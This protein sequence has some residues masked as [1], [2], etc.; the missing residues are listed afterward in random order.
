MEH[1]HTLQQS[2]GEHMQDIEREAIE[3]EGRNHQSFLTACRVA[4]QACPPEACGIPM[5][6][7]QL[8]MGNMSLATLLAISPGHPPQWEKWPL[9]LPIQLHQW[10][11]HPNGDAVH[12]G[13][14]LLDQLLLP[15]NLLIRTEKRESPSQGSMKTAWRPFIRTPI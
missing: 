15:K 1:A 10:H 12:L 8:L 5:Y 3:E 9:Q 11:P 6:P 4:L 7:L 14:R 13:R 2:N